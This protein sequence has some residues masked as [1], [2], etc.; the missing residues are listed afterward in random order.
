MFEGDTIECVQNFKYL[1]ILLETTSNLDNAVEHFAITNKCLLFAL[2]HRCADLCIMD[3]KVRYDLFNTL[4]HSIT[5]F[6]CEI[7]VD[8]KKI[9]VIEIVYQGFFKSMLGAQKTTNTSI[10]LAKFGKFPFE[11]FTWGQLLLY[12]KPMNM[13]TKNHILGKAWEAQLAMLTAGK[14]CWVGF[15]KKWLFKNQP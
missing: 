14:K 6:V 12:Y 8:S 15:M 7:W 13:F 3:V 5:S 1:G 4:V 10:V 11:H 2:N 9:K